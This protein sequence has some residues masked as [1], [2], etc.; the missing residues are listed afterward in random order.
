MENPVA[1]HYFLNVFFSPRAYYEA[2]FTPPLALTS[3]P[4]TPAV[5]A[6]AFGL[7][8]LPACLVGQAVQRTFPIRK[9]LGGELLVARI[10]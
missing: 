3:G 2:G 1:A 5:Q 9:Y 4:N 7:A 10:E 6:T 8:C